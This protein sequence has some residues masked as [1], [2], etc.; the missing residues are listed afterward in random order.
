[1]DEPAAHSGPMR[2]IKPVPKRHI[3]GEIWAKSLLAGALITGAGISLAAWTGGAPAW[4]ASHNP[5]SVSPSRQQARAQAYAALSPLPLFKVSSDDTASA[6]NGMQLPPADQQA[7]RAELGVPAPAPQAGPQ[8]APQAAV[9]G[10]HQT[11][12]A[13][14]TLWD[15]DAEDGDV[16]K[17]DSM[18]YTR[19]VSLRHQPQTFAVPVPTDGV[20]QITGLRDG[21]GGGITVGLASGAAQ[22]VFPVMSTGQVLGLKVRLN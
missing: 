13:W 17:L 16:V 21:E 2:Q 15:T 3:L 12:L 20:V 11:A 8:A 9:V 5:D 7:L 1:M 14:I 10:R 18:G 4:D 22:A 19:T 6:I